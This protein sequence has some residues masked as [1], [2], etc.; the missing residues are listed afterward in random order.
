MSNIIDNN[1]SGLRNQTLSDNKKSQGVSGVASKVA[2]SPKE[3]RVTDGDNVDISTS[4]KLVQIKEKIDNT[5]EVDSAKVEA[6]KE[7]IASGEYPIDADRIAGK[8][9]DLEQLLS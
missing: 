4:A 5:P 2:D 1:S 7:K 3:S 9:I 6:I 8:F